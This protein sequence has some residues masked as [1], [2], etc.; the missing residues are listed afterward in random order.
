MIFDSFTNKI[1]QRLRSSHIW[2]V[3]PGLQYP[4]LAS[5]VKINNLIARYKFNQIRL[6]RVIQFYKLIG[7]SK[8]SE[9]YRFNSS[10]KQ[11]FPYLPD[12]T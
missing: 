12:K 7:G 3:F 8:T 4:S 6:T 10:R 9:S 1:V 11:L 2:E 5:T